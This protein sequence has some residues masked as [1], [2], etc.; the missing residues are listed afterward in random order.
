[1]PE[2]FQ[3]YLILRARIEPSPLVQLLESY[4][5]DLFRPC[6]RILFRKAS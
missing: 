3:L 4:K 5:K 2:V 6:H 1:M